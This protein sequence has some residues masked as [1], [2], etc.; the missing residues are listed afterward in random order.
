MPKKGVFFFNEQKNP[1]QIFSVA[2]NEFTIGLPRILLGF[3]SGY[4]IYLRPFGSVKDP[5]GCQTSLVF[6][7]LFHGQLMVNCWFGARWFGF[8]GSPKM[9]GIV[10]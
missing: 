8:L 2:S 6:F 5:L 1:Q 9:K 10:T 7:G 3:I 4:V